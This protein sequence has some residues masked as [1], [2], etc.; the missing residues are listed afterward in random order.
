[1]LARQIISKSENEK[2]L[3][4]LKKKIEGRRE[5]LL[6]TCHIL[7]IILMV[8]WTQSWKDRM[9]F[10]LIEA[11]ETNSD[12]SIS[13]IFHFLSLQIQIHETFEQTWSNT[14]KFLDVYNISRRL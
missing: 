12:D 13:C 14:V 9:C 2:M 8:K 1:M 11:I 4:T 7:C 5:I 3:T 10:K 6:P